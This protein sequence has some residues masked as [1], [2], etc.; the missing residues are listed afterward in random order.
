[1]V[2]TPQQTV[3]SRYSGATGSSRSSVRFRRRCTDATAHLA[4][5]SLAGD[6][7]AAL[8][9]GGGLAARRVVSWGK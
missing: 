4:R 9:A 3:R 7:R 5:L 8:D 2:A 6:A 1:M